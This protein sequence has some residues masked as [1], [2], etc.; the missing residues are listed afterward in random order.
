MFNIYGV[1]ATDLYS[2]ATSSTKAEVTDD[3]TATIFSIHYINNNAAISY[4]QIFDL[5]ADA[6]TVGS[7]VPTYVLAVPPTSAS[8]FTFQKPIL[9]KTGFTIASATT[10]TGSSNSAG[11]VTIVYTHKA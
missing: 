7:T 3:P 1:Q 10:A 4:L 11:Y 5:D 2:A 6:V 9:H 8:T